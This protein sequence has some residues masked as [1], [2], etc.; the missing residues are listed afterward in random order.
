[1]EER[2]I[3]RKK[4]ITST[5]HETTEHLTSGSLGNIFEFRSHFTAIQKEC[6]TPP[7]VHPTSRYIT[8]HDQFD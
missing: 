5:D 4:P 2:H 1:V 3:P 7:H 8:A 6:A